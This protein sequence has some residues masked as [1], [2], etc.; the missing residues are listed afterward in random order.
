MKSTLAMGWIA[1]FMSLLIAACAAYF[2]I[3]GLAVIFAAALWPVIIMA[4]VLE[5]GKIGS[6]FFLHRYWDALSFGLKY[7]L[8]VMVIILMIITSMGIF[9][10]LS[11]GHIEQET[12]V[13]TNN[14]QIE[15]IDQQIN[16]RKGLID[17]Q[18]KRLGTLQ[19]IVDTLIKYDRI[20]G[21]DGAD[22]TLEQQQPERNKIQAT[23]DKTYAEINELQEKRLPF[24]SKV[25]VIEAKLGPI[26]YVA[27]LFGYDLNKDPEGKGKAVRIV[28]ILFMLAFDPLA[29]WLIMSSDWA[30]ILYRKESKEVKEEEAEEEQDVEELQS[31]LIDV[32]KDLQEKKVELKEY[33][34]VM[35]ELERTLDE[36]PTEIE[37]VIEVENTE[38]ITEM[39]DDIQQLQSQR[40]T[41]EEDLQAMRESLSTKESLA[42]ELRA[43]LGEVRNELNSIQQENHLLRNDIEARDNV[44]ASLNNKYNLVE[45][46]PGMIARP[47]NIVIGPAAFGTQFPD[48]PSKG[49]QFLRVDEMPSK[50]FKYDGSQ[51]L[52][53]IKSENVEY[54]EKYLQHMI[55]QLGDGYIGLDEL[56]DKE[57][58][59][60]QNLL[61]EEEDIL[62]K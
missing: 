31:A 29:I 21:S 48:S 3:V 20:R 12:P 45:K 32:Y 40:D 47:D 55:D 1:L 8:A 56:S 61:S 42:E 24:Q 44:V 13:A 57:Q 6:T 5:I 62:G 19:Q 46:I 2:S 51:W 17:R 28:I 10:F 39:L 9:G 59:E 25:N 41:I 52:E 36:K 11:K 49:Q 60:I 53:V 50:L 4:S 38:K 54:S 43:A 14:L 7:P 27:Q 23:V 22:A 15:R 30:F 58:A 35:E 26:K 34:A 16:S 18:E 37:K 33:L